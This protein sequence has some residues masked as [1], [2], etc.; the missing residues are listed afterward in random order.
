MAI[1]APA[2]LAPSL[3]AGEI[4]GQISPPESA[5]AVFAV[6]RLKN[7]MKE[8]RREDH[9]GELNAETGQFT[10]KGLADGIYDLLIVTTRGRIEGVDLEVQG[11]AAK[12]LSEQDLEE[13]KSRIAKMDEFMN[14]KKALFI[15]GDQSRAKALMDL[16]RDRVHHMGS[17]LIWRIEIW[18]FENLYGSWQ[19]R[20]QGRKGRKTL[21]RIKAPRDQVEAI[22]YL[23]EPR[24]GGIRVNGDQPVEIPKYRIPKDWQTHPG[25]APVKYLPERKA[26]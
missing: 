13:L 23:F 15:Q 25:S 6:Q 18:Q 11:D 20:G 22:R 12:P 3:D 5:R 1:L 7:T 17:D 10:I 19:L 24:L 21:H 9:P 26:P 2:A 14:R 4:V 16:C 8:I